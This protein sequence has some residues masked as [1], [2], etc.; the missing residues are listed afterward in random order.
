MTE[1]EATT[2]RGAPMAVSAFDLYSIGIGPSS[3]HTVGPM[4]AARAF[5]E[6]YP[7]AERLRVDLFGSLAATGRGHGTD[8]AI[9]LRLEGEDPATV[10]T[11]RVAAG[12]APIRAERK[13]LLGG[14]RAV[15]FDPDTDLVLHRRESLPF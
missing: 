14:K 8:A 4:R 7:K 9:L 10:D 1:R 2:T 5:A 12:G 3:S 13:L 6:A 11:G 15:A